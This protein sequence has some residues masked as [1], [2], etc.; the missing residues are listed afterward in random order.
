MPLDLRQPARI[1]IACILVTI[2]AIP[3]GLLAQTHLVTPAD[4]QKEMLAAA[5]AR[6]RHLQILNEFLSSQTAEKALKSAH[7]NPEQVKSA[8][9]T[10][11]DG[12]LAQ[13]ASRAEKAQTNFAAGV[14]S[15]RDL[16]FII[17]GIAVL[18]LIIVAVR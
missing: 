2:F 14:L 15:D 9:S 7:M 12:E 1:L 16:I 10:L 13:L 3:P 6:Q 4:L 11:S 17:L 5:Q 8:V 18:V